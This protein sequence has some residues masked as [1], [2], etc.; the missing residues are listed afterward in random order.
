MFKGIGDA[1]KQRSFYRLW[2]R[3]EAWLKGKGAGFS[4]L[5]LGLDDAH[6][7]ALFSSAQ[8]WSLMN[9]P[10]AKGYVGALGV[11]GAVE[12]VERFC[13]EDSY[14]ALQDS[15]GLILVTEWLEYRERDFHKIL[16]LM[17]KPAIFDGRNVY[18]PEKIRS[19]GFDYFAIGRP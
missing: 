19:L 6:L 5:H 2:T 12:R 4:E 11:K 15:E 13:F 18:K 8:G 9:M 1:R 17:K 3:K 7:P 14:K 16:S 10:V